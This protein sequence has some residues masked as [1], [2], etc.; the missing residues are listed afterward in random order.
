MILASDTSGRIIS[1]ALLTDDWLREVKYMGKSTES[2]HFFRQVDY[3]LKE[4]QVELSDLD[5]L[6]IGSG[7]G[8]FTGLRIS[9]SGFKAFAQSKDIPLILINSLDAIC[10]PWRHLSGIVVVAQRARRGFAFCGFYRQGNLL[11]D[12]LYLSMAELVDQ[13]AKQAVTVIGT[14]AGDLVDV[15]DGCLIVPHIIGPE[16]V[17]IAAMAKI[18][19]DAQQFT[20]FAE[21]QPYYMRKSDAEITM[22]KKENAKK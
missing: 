2:S 6:A 11:G 20:A 22:E 21:A 1:T 14:F 9:F 3:L 15:K 17:D 10:W 8:S 7:P 12:Y 19:F 13:L 18:K 16:A 4:S 5:A